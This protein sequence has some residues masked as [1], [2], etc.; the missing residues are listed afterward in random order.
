MMFKIRSL[1]PISV[2]LGHIYIAHL[3]TLLQGLVHPRLNLKNILTKKKHA[4]Q[5]I[6]HKKK[7]AH[8][9]PL[10]KEINDLNVHQINI[11][12][13]LTTI[14]KVKDTTIPKVFL[15]S[16]EEIKHKCSTCFS[17]YFN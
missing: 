4:V 8:A 14:L 3:Y 1:P 17:K 6:F 5:F 9:R 2:E 16:F 10:L 11:L 13:I 7:K 15:S 12:R